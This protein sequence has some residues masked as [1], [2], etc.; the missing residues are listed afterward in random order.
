[1]SC[2]KHYYIN[3]LYFCDPEIQEINLDEKK[4][5][6]WFSCNCSCYSGYH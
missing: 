4:R 6:N 1:M 5:D 2:N 3:V